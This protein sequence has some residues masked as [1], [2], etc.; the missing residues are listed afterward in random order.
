MQKDTSEEQ[1]LWQSVVVMGTSMLISKT[2]VAAA[3]RI[4]RCTSPAHLEVSASA[5]LSVLL[6][7]CLA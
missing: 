4:E 3:P 1:S 6:E 2:D 7:N 5:W